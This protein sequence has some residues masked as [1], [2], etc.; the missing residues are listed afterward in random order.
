MAN[1]IDGK[2]IA[3][4]TRAR[5]AEEAAALKAETG[6]TP[7]LAVILVG[8]DPASAIYVENKKKACE[9]LGFYS[10]SFHLPADTGREALLTLLDELNHDPAI[11][12]I[13]VQLPLP[14]H[15][16]EGEI[17]GAVAPEKDVD[18]FTSSN[19]GRIV[20]GNFDLVPCTPAGIMELLRAYGVDPDGKRAVVIGRSDI[21]GKPMAL[22]LLHA[23]A[24][25]TI[26]HSHTKDLAAICRE[27]DILVSAVGKA[28]FVTADMIKP[29]AVVI[30]VGMNRTEKG[31]VGD[32]DF[33]AASAVADLITPVPGGVGPM[34]ITMLM[35]NTLTAA[36]RAAK[37]R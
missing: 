3:A 2:M 19:V 35:K 4:K 34:T 21:V 7:G 11:H 25:V 9:A 36:K 27:A 20:A 32:V 17:T 37:R 10:R 22:L 23:N 30:D 1:I 31:L 29:G 13:L 33:D 18:A 15:L 28:D 26:C 6:V 16:D 14:S 5:L 12:G 24:T 8:D